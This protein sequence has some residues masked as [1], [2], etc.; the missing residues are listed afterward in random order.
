MTKKE[1]GEPLSISMSTF[2]TVCICPLVV[3]H[4]IV[5][6]AKHLTQFMDSLNYTVELS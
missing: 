2:P 4:G 3:T 5:C 1:Y 6:I